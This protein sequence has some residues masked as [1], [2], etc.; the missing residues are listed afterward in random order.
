LTLRTLSAAFLAW[1]LLAARPEPQGGFQQ[2]DAANHPDL[3]VW[4]DSANVWVIRDGDAALL[5]N[6]GDGSVLGRLGDIGVKQAEWVLFTHHTREGTQ[7]AARLRDSGAKL[8]GPE[9]ER[10]LFERPANYRRMSVKL[11]DPFTVHGAS[12]VRPPIEPIKLDRVFKKM[13]TLSW[14]GREVWCADTRGASPGAMS[15]LLKDRGRWLAFTGDLMMD[16]AKMHTWFDAEWDY[17]FAAGVYALANSAGQVQG[18]DPAWLLPSHGPAVKDAARPLA[19]YQEKLRR[20]EKALVRGYDVNT[21]SGATQDRLSRPSPVPH[22]WQVLP[23]LY[24]FRGPNFYPNMSLLIADSGRGLAMDCGLFDE[25]FLDESIA[26]MKERMGLK[27]IDAVVI[28]HMHGD[29]FLQAPHLRKNYGTQ[30]WAIDRMGPMCE[31]PERFDY[32]ASIQ[33]YGQ[34]LDGGA[35]IEGV[36]FDRLFKDGET[37]EWEGYK[38]QIDWMPGQTEF[39]CA[40]QGVIDGKKVVFTGDN[41]FGD[42]SDPRHTGHEAVVAHNSSILEEGYIYGAEYLARLKPDLIMGGHSYVMPEPA[43]FIE[44]YR[45]W[46]YEMRDA[47]KVLSSEDD[48]RLWYDP[49][50]VRAEP[51]RVKVKAGE[52]V[53]VAMHVRNFR[54]R[55]QVHRIEVHAP[56]GIEADPPRLEGELASEARKPFPLKLRAAADAKPGVRIVAFDVTLDGRRYG[57]RFDVIVEVLP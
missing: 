40:L 22:V 17:G 45:K 37:F 10:D 57:E 2:P 20:L 21:F 8:A 7:G 53:E 14:R 49:F 6:I 32:S 24:K 55:V 3:F 13:D 12:Y 47:F 4:T 26:L 30:I 46:S 35:P 56:P 50:W 43:G 5:V 54:P 1:A 39:A 33:A 38:F 44:R 23:H 42:S 19:E 25:K 52:S 51:Y 27:T 36:K 11:S 28:S 31:H 41:L 18:Y 48:Y 29:H 34:K 9:A 15:Y 16:G